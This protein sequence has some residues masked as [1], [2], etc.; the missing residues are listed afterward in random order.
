MAFFVAVIFS[1][2]AQ[3]ADSAPVDGSAAPSKW[4]PYV[5]GGYVH[6]FDS[7][8]GDSSF[9]VDRF[10]VQG[11]MSYSAGPRRRI[12]FAIG[13]GQ[14]NTTSREAWARRTNPGTGSTSLDS[15]CRSL[16]VS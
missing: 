3:G 6:Q 15:A 5:R 8:L 2:A 9:E 12:S 14:E 10:F 7:D 4:S 16:G 1:A 11:G 13:A